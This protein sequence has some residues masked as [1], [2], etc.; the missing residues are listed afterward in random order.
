MP[1]FDGQIS[2]SWLTD[3]ADYLQAQSIGT[4]STSLFIGNFE[5]E[6]REAV[7]LVPSGGIVQNSHAKQSPSFQITV[8][9]ASYAT[10]FAKAYSIFNLLNKKGNITQGTTRFLYF[11]AMGIPLQINNDILDLKRFVLNFTVHL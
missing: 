8:R 10:G 5:P 2:A 9:S 1:D 6:Y 4:L 7:L 11:K 3:L